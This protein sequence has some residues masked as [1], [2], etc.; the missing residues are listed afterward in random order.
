[1]QRLEGKGRAAHSQNQRMARQEDG[2]R[3]TVRVE[4]KR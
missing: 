3:L 4:N 1:M 2:D